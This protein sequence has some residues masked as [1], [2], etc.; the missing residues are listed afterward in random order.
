MTGNIP[1][2]HSNYYRPTRANDWTELK[3]RLEEAVQ[4]GRLTQAQANRILAHVEQ[5]SSTR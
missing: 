5:R 3:E 1:P 2:T 4:E